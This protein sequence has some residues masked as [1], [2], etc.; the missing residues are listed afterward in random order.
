MNNFQG[1]SITQCILVLAAI[2]YLIYV[3]VVE[4]E[5]KPRKYII[6]PIIFAFIAFSSLD[7][8]KGGLLRLSTGIIL[9]IIIGLICGIFAGFITQIYEK[10]DGNTYIKGG[11]QMLI[12]LIISIPIRFVLSHFITSLPQDIGLDYGTAYLIRL[13]FQLIA[14]SVVIYFRVPEFWK[15]YNAQRERRGAKRERKRAK[16]EERRAKRYATKD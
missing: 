3:Q 15:I 11:W 14:R 7:K 2:A 8:I 6:K 4:R 9:L 13:T 1:I 5:F 10:E 16:R 12:F